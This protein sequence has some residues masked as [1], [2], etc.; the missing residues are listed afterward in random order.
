MAKAYKQITTIEKAMQFIYRTSWKGSRLG[1]SRMRE[2]MERLG[3]PEKKMRFVHIA[4]TNGKG[5]TASMLAGILKEAGYKT[6]LYT[7]PVI[8]TFGERAQVNG[9]PITEA[10]IID[11]SSRLQKH[12]D[13]MRDLPTEFEI[14]TA[15]SLLYFYE[16]G[17]E[18]VVLE[19]GMG[20]RLDATNIIGTP[21]AAVIT[22]IG[23]DHMEELGHT[24]EMIAE[25]KAGII[26]A[27][28]VVICHPQAPSVERVIRNKCMEQGS[29]VIFVDDASIA[30]AEQ[31]LEGQ[32]FAYNAINNLSIPLLG[33]HQLCNA[34]VAIKTSQALRERGWSI[35][36]D[37]LRNGLKNISWPGRFEVIKR[38][39]V[40][41]VD[42][43]HNP[44]GVQTAVD[45]LRSLFPGK[46]LL[47]LFG[48]LADKDHQAML[49]ILVPQASRFITVMPDS[50]RALPTS[51]LN[52]D[53]KDI[54]VTPCASVEQGIERALELAEDDDVICSLGTMS[55]VGRIREYLLSH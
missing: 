15:L 8:H 35:T 11:I 17:C 9:K 50:P 41:I 48:V 42:S 14:I 16:M 39:P 52:F 31:S 6:G 38:S 53:G 20:G 55:M 54:A 18:I 23:L 10:E 3:N 22:S 13:R 32:T 24:V 5:S 2:L 25:E 40:F 21:E 7:S 28:G 27:G 36:E 43:A 45:T 47:F 1:L 37:A 26:K 4:G 12:V 19:V 46:R 51:E 29:G 34:A 30:A 49:D 33:R 44:Q